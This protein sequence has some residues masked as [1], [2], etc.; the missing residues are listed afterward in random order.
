[1]DKAMSDRIL[2]DTGDGTW[3][4]VSIESPGT[5]VL[6]IAE[7][8]MRRN[9]KGFILPD[10]FSLNPSHKHQTLIFYLSTAVTS[11]RV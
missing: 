5:L 6:K 2:K 3:Q 7:Q 8:N 4:C 11:W 9:W 1:M 10:V